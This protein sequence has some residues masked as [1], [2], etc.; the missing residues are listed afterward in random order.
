LHAQGRTVNNVLEPSKKKYRAKYL[1][2]TYLVRVTRYREVIGLTRAMWHY[3]TKKNDTEVIDVLTRLVEEL[4]T[5]GFEV[6]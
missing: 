1:K 6:N 4:L 3:H 2:E 5:R